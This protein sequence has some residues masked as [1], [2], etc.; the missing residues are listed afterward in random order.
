MGFFCLTTLKYCGFSFVFNATYKYSIWSNISIISSIIQG[1]FSV[2]CPHPDIF[3]VARIEKVLQGG[4][5][6]CAEP[7]MKSSDSTKVP[8]HTRS[9]LQPPLKAVC[10]P[11]LS[12]FHQII[13][14]YAQI[15]IPVLSADQSHKHSTQ[16]LTLAVQLRLCTLKGPWWVVMWFRRGEKC[17]MYLHIVKEECVRVLSRLLCVLV[18]WLAA[19]WI[20]YSA[21]WW[22]VNHCSCFPPGG[23]E[24]P[25][26]C[27]AGM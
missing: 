20:F 23:T 8:T 6:H 26:K 17:E 9:S 11:V 3:L 7:Y 25:E 1:V 21:K 16:A 4:I 10:S 15:I 22:N 5:N 24:G 18:L 2:T 13:L 12:R 19:C 14:H 27:Q